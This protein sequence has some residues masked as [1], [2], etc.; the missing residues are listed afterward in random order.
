MTEILPE[1]NENGSEELSFFN[2]WRGEEPQTILGDTEGNNSD[3]QVSPSGSLIPLFLTDVEFT[4]MLSSLYVGAEFAYPEKYLQIVW[5]LLR[6]VQMPVVIAETCYEWPPNSTFITYPLQNP[7]TDPDMVPDGYVIPPMV[8]ITED[9]IEDFPQNEVGDVVAVFNSFPLDTGWFDDINED[10]PSVIISVEGTGECNIRLLNQVQGGLAIITLDNPPNLVDIL[11]GIITGADNIIDV[12]MDIVSLPPETAI[13][14]I[15]PIKI[16]TEGV[17]TIYV[18]FFPI[19]DD[20]LIPVR[21]GG[22]FRGIELCGFGSATMG[23]QDIRMLNIAGEGEPANWYLQKQ[24][25]GVWDYVENWGEFNSIVQIAYQHGTRANIM[26]EAL[27][28]V[29]GEGWEYDGEYVGFVDSPLQEYIDATSFDPSGLEADIAA[30]AAAAAAAQSTANG[31]VTVN[32]T[33]NTA[34]T[35]QAG[36]IGDLQTRMTDAETDIS[37]QAA[38]IISLDNR[39]DALDFGNAWAWIHDMTLA[40]NGYV[41]TGSA[42][43]GYS[44]GNG[45]H[46]DS[47]GLEIYYATEQVKQNQIRFV[48]VCVRYASAPTGTPQFHVNGGDNAPIQYNGVGV[49]SYGWYAVPNTMELDFTLTFL[50]SGDFY[51]RYVRYLG[52]GIVLPFD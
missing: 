48:E 41:L 19:I 29:G 11:A 3:A 24:V 45:W 12:N 30:A 52:K 8:V 49:D 50:G 36:Y 13:E 26:A 51:L 18:V 1:Y 43:S 23:V 32:N 39:V 22:G 44:S 42:G 37:G 4:E 33:Q 34:I 16:E 5:Y 2:S 46:S 14:H 40:S 25:G 27:R 15:Y 7:Y 21:F 17:H 9:N 28:V 35:A 20:S 10:L 6:A 38:S 31:A 47:N